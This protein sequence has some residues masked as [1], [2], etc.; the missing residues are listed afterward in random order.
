MSS[1]TVLHLMNPPPMAIQILWVNTW[2]CRVGIPQQSRLTKPRAEGTISI[3]RLLP[4]HTLGDGFIGM[5]NILRSDP[6]L[7]PADRGGSA[8]PSG[9]DF[10]PPRPLRREFIQERVM[11]GQE[12]MGGIAQGHSGV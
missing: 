3:P 9:A 2:Q 11:A 1:P 7:S 4:H 8:S 5:G 12:S 10:R 6:G